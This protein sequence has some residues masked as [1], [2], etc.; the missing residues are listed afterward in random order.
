M[1]CS[2][3]IPPWA[4]DSINGDGSGSGYGY[5]DGYGSGDS[6]GSGDGSGDGYGCGDGSG[7]G[8]G[9][10][11]GSGDGCGYGDGYGYGSGSGSG[12][13][14]GDGCGYGDGYGDGYGSGYGSGDGYGYGDGSGSGYWH[15]AALA[16]I[17]KWT[18]AQ[19][20]RLS[21][22]GGAFVAFWRSDK[23]GK[24]SNGGNGAP[25]GVGSVQEIAGPLVLCGPRALHATMN[26]DKWRGERVWI[27]A[28]HGEV[29][30][31]DD[32]CG[33]LKREILGEVA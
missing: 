7:Y 27:V 17:A 26:P 4:D 11:Y 13:G 1:L 28:L 5:G 29:I 30:H 16:A 23:H 20:A 33:A 2:G 32:K 12:Y 10:G 25:V 21:G 9:S 15:L 18:D 3:A 19:R 14:Y 6:Y 31:Q 8:Y 22:I 24:P